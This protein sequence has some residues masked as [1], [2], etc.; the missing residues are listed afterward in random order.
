MRLVLV[1]APVLLRSTPADVYI[2]YEL[3]FVPDGTLAAAGMQEL[4]TVWMDVMGLMPYPVFDL[5]RDAGGRDGRYTYPGESGRKGY[6][7]NRWVVQQDGVLVG[8]AGHLHPGGLWTDLTLRRGGKRTRRSPPAPR[9]SAE[10]SAARAASRSQC[11][12]SPGGRGT[13]VVSRCADR[14]ELLH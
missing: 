8:T 1:A 7:R 11:R 3:E 10:P 2:D 14:H 13:S 12:L 6:S 5:H 9:S 4:R